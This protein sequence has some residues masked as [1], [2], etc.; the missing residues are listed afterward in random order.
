M[1]RQT[2]TL[3]LTAES[4]LFAAFSVSYN[5]AQPTDEGRSPFYA[6]GYFSFVIVLAI[7]AVAISAGASWYSLFEP[8][9]PNGWNEWLRAGG[10]AVPIV[11]QPFFAFAIAI[12]A[13]KS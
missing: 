8:D 7:S 6:Q 4:L 9:P 2:L 1:P 5:L 13:R 10:L 11:S 3:A 12:Q